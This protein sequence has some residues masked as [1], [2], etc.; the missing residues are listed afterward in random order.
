MAEE[1]PKK[2]INIKK[3]ALFGLGPIVLIGVGLGIGISFHANP[4]TG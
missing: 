4:D 3:I 2:K 1:E